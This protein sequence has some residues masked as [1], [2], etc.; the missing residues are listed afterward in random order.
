MDALV[1]VS[2][3]KKRFGGLT[4]VDGISFQVK[5][6]DVLG[7]LGPNGSGKTTTMRMV[8][9]YL[10]PTQGRITVCGFDIQRKRTEAQARIG[11]LPEG[12]PLYE[13]MTPKGILSFVC[14][15][16]GLDRSKKVKSIDEVVSLFKL[17]PVLE[18]EIG[19]LSRGFKRRV[20][21]ATA[22]VHKPQ[23]LILDEPTDGLDPNQKH[24]V[25]RLI[26][27][28]ARD[29][30]RAIIISTH[31]LEEVDAVCTRAIIIARGR[32]ATE[33]TPDELAATSPRHN[34]VHLRVSLDKAASF[35]STL[36]R[37][38]SVDD[39]TTDE[40]VN[41]QAH[42]IVVPRDGKGIAGQISAIAKTSSVRIE[43]I[44]TERGH[45]DEVFREVTTRN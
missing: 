45:L 12:A 11:Y 20:A 9:G 6:G 32:I 31:I 42:L 44:Y 26:R 15:V 33:G 5:G 22:F 10:P 7:F 29:E 27:H 16:R 4:A 41:G 36:M 34:A 28:M 24:E 8:T 21:L 23:V 1:E 38:P 17:E 35:R 43:E 14:D 25:R 3:L 19:T 13:E 37:H 18:Q 40:N 2:N 39:V 30:N